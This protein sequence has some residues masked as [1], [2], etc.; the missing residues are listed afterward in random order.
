M[1]SFLP[2]DGSGLETGFISAIFLKDDTEAEP[3][4][5]ILLISFLTFGGDLLSSFPYVGV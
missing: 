5:V 1:L 2:G 4:V 3:K